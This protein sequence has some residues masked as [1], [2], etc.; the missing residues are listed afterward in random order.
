MSVQEVTT[1]AVRKTLLR[2]VCISFCT[3]TQEA[4]IH[5]IPPRLLRATTQQEI[6]LMKHTIWIIALALCVLGFAVPEAASAHEHIYTVANCVS[7]AVCGCGFTLGKPNPNRHTGATKLVDAV[8]AKEFEA[9]YSGDKY[10]ADC[11]A[12]LAK[13]EV[14]PATHKHAFTGATCN[15]PGV[16]ACG[17]AGSTN[18]SIHVG[19]REVRDFL[20][21]G[22]FTNGYTG[23][24]YCL[25]C[26]LLIQYGERI[27]MKHQT[28]S[29]AAATCI[30]PATCACGLTSGEKNPN[31][32]DGGTVL[33]H[34]V[35]AQ[36][37]KTGYSGDEYCLGC[38]TMLKKGVV[39]P[40]T[41]QH[42]YNTYTFNANQH[43]QICIAGD[44]STE[45]ADHQFKVYAEDE[46]GHRVRCFCGATR[47]I[48][49]FDENKNDLCDLCGH[50]M[51][52]SASGISRPAASSD[53]SPE[54]ESENTPANDDE[55]TMTLLHAETGNSS[56]DY[57]YLAPTA[58]LIRQLT[59]DGNDFLADGDTYALTFEGQLGEQ[60][61][62]QYDFSAPGGGSVAL[63]IDHPQVTDVFCAAEVAGMLLAQEHSTELALTSFSTQVYAGRLTISTE[64]LSSQIDQSITGDETTALPSLQFQF[65]ADTSIQEYSVF[66]GGN[67][68]PSTFTGEI[69]NTGSQPAA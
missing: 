27:P 68:I 16:C 54:Q 55:Y 37:F 10:C 41:H 25:D 5:L 28:H 60:L 46:I 31:R 49:H 59:L 44:A 39:T 29:Y 3:Q 30:A 65:P 47:Y 48:A 9:G 63:I 56:I 18:A 21:A 43:W 53:A 58:M 34:V 20:A 12:L 52:D 69:R 51:K 32:H 42:S 66:Y 19:K 38:G 50:V 14:L 24:T 2:A 4:Y 45:K 62:I 13:G 15:Q 7:P 1:H 40:I 6:F 8:P 33:Q 36:E 35:P 67:E 22:E 23:N 64:D 61:I 26:G 17:A 57:I 11:N